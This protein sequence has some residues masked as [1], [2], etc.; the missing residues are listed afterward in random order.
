MEPVTPAIG[1]QTLCTQCGSAI[2]WKGEHW[3]HVGDKKPRHIAIPASFQVPA[4]WGGRPAAAPAQP[5]WTKALESREW[6]QVLHAL[7]Y[8]RNHSGAG[9]PGHG[10]FLLIAKLAKLLDEREPHDNE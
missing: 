10:Q 4:G 3:D 5:E 8:A 1:M 2:E 9:A 7:D 6:S